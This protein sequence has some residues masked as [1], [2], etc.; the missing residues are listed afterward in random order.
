MKIINPLLGKS[1]YQR[2]G[3]GYASY[4]FESENVVHIRYYEWI[5]SDNPIKLDGGSLFPEK[6]FFKNIHFDIKNRIFIGLIDWTLPEGKTI[7]GESYW[8]Y[9]MHFNEEFEIIDNGYVINNQFERISEFGKSLKYVDSHLYEE[10]FAEAKANKERGNIKEEKKSTSFNMT[11]A[12]NE[13]T[14]SIG[15][16]ETAIAGAKLLGKG[17][18]NVAKFAISTAPSAAE[19]MTKEN[20]RKNE[21][22]LRRP[23]LSDEQREKLLEMREKIKL[24]L[25]KIASKKST[26]NQST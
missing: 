4:H 20:L 16:K 3:L 1:F 15:A 7:R 10:T 23:D 5:N 2:G 19:S 21:E 17:L 6:K 11:E 14:N 8:L 13:V 22:L 26:E 25:Q 18:F 12:V 24:E 9:M